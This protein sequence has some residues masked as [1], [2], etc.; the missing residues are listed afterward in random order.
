MINNFF[1][2]TELICVS[3]AQWLIALVTNPEFVSN[4][5]RPEWKILTKFFCFPNSMS[6]YRYKVPLINAK[7]VP[8]NNYH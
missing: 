7:A 8:E 4:Q 3:M 6:V 5:S 2:N 1:C